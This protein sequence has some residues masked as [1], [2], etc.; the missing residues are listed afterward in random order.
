MPRVQK[1]TDE[2]LIRC[3]NMGYG[4]MKIAALYDMGKTPIRKRLAKLELTDSSRGC[5]E[6]VSDEILIDAYVNKGFGI[7]KISKEYNISEHTIGRRLKRLGISDSSKQCTKL[8][9]GKNH[10]SRRKPFEFSDSVK[11][12]RFEEENGICQICNQLVDS[13]LNWR[14]ATYHHIVCIKDGGNGSKENCMVL[15]SKCHEDNS[16]EL[17]GFSLDNYK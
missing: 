11:K 12:Q 5:E 6:K 9:D 7:K 8:E 3:Y 4:I 15:H 2:D 17:H 13:N 1:I 16:Y 10:R 14:V